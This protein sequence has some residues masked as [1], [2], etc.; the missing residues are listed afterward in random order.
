MLRPDNKSV[1]YLLRYK[2]LATCTHPIQ[3]ENVVSSTVQIDLT[4]AVM[5]RSI[6]DNAHYSRLR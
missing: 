6:F 2:M 4:E 5:G 1:C 3:T